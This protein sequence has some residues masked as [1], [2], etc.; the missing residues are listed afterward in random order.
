MT[1]RR[2]VPIVLV[3]V[4]LLA[5]PSA[6][7]GL[8]NLRFTPIHLA[9][10]SKTILM[11]KIKT[12]GIANE[13]ELGVSAVLKGKA[14]A[15]LVI[16]LSKAS[17]K[18]HADEARKLLGG[19][20]ERAVLLFTADSVGLAYLHVNGR[21]LKLSGKGGAWRLQ[22]VSEKMLS[23]WDGGTDMLARCIQY[24]LTERDT[25]S[26]PGQAGIRWRAV[27]KIGSVGGRA[28]DITAVDLVGDGTC[29][30]F[31]TGDK[32]DR[33]LRPGKDGAFADIT[34]KV[35]LGSASRLASWGDYDGNG[36]MDLASYDG[37]ALTIWTRG[38]DGTFSAA[39][40]GGTFDMPEACV[41]MATIA[42]GTAKTPGLLLSVAAGRPVLLKPAG[43][44][45]FEAIKLAA[46]ALAPKDYG[47]SQACLVA[48]FN[49]DSLI[50]VVQPFE[51][52][53]LIYRGK[54]DGSFEAPTPC[55]ICSTVGGG[56]AALGDFDSDGLP[57]VLIAGAEGVKIFQNRGNGVFA[58][59]LGA[60]GEIA[61]KNRPLASWCGVG[62]F[63]NGCRPGIFITYGN[64]PMLLYFN[65]GFRTFGQVPRREMALEEITNFRKGQQMALAADLGGSGVQDL[66]VVAGNG[67]IWCAFNDLDS[68]GDALCIRARMPAV[69]PAAGPVNVSAWKRKRCLGTSVV[70]AGA[71]PGF[72][73]I[74][75][76]GKYTVK[77]RLPGRAEMSREVSVIDKPVTV[78]LEP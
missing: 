78:V 43:K 44:N 72:F 51:K 33:L 9:D 19:S 29:C 26:V 76:P 60:S 38:G 75:K 1:N 5:L 35:K 7:W 36:R 20:A 27:K 62:D 24:V 73:G 3:V 46:P 45:A 23:T 69:S 65:R 55:A 37:K 59:S 41:G 32:G 10:Q 30:L 17:R 40:P 66:F 13:V 11:A 50:D 54:K 21:W 48:D 61:Y 12:K 64:Q 31:V 77:W 47:K 68:D 15:R 2:N 16:D 34:A 53:G 22:A 4:S 18:E 52:G 39:R 57:D 70:Q 56:K 8:I 6:A 28:R 63:S 42:V 67:D 74:D 25:A 71:A 49:N 14:P 58:E